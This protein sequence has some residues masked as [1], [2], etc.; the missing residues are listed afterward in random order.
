MKKS[1]EKTVLKITLG[2]FLVMLLGI[3]TIL[4]TA[5]MTEP[6]PNKKE[7]KKRQPVVPF[8]QAI[9]VSQPIVQDDEEENEYINDEDEAKDELEDE[10][11][12]EDIPI[13]GTPLEK[14]SAAALE[15]IGE[16]RV[17]DTEVGD[18]EGY[19]EIEV[20][21]DNGKEVDVHLDEN[22][23]VLSVE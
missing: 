3:S 23:N 7:I 13:T 19:Y 18:E 21:L 20:T 11:E 17:T 10:N 14:A 9:T 16:G 15:Y 22:Y 5:L 4:A 12:P 1:S 6:E 8:Q 2:L